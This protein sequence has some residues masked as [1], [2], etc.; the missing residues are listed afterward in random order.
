VD[1]P[2]ATLPRVRHEWGLI[3]NEQVVIVPDSCVPHLR[4]LV[5]PK[6]AHVLPTDLPEAA[7][8]RLGQVVD[9]ISD[10]FRLVTGVSRCHCW[11]PHPRDCKTRRLHLFVDPD[12]PALD[13]A[14]KQ[15]V[16]GKVAVEIRR[17]LAGATT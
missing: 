9:A 10:A 1:C 3:E 17:A 8:Q 2:Q 16:W 5:V 13:L 12:L 7:L 4:A 15:A 14:K 11:V 6:A